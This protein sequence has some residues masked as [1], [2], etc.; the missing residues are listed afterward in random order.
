H[1]KP[2]IAL[3]NATGGHQ[4]SP[5]R[6][7]VPALLVTALRSLARL[8][9]LRAG[10]LFAAY[11][12]RACFSHLARLALACLCCLRQAASARLSCCA[13]DRGLAAL[14]FL[15]PCSAI[16]VFCLSTAPFWATISV[17][18]D[19]FVEQRLNFAFSGRFAVSAECGP[20]GSTVS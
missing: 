11:C 15:Q 12:L 3:T 1:V 18:I 2:A 7:R 4:S 16:L 6:P 20:S 13:R 17:G 8:A 9:R 14:T 5:R 19:S 10:F